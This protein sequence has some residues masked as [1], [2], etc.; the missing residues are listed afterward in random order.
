MPE[1]GYASLQD[2]EQAARALKAELVDLNTNLA[3]RNATD[4]NGNRLHPHVY[5]TQRQERLAM[6]LARERQLRLTKEWIQ[7]WREVAPAKAIGIDPNDGDS[8]LSA[9]RRTLLA[10]EQ[11]GFPLDAEASVLVEAAQNYLRNRGKA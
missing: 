10:Q 3:D 1:I 5:H 7:H 4:A 11:Q 2:A 6:K 9:M 8:L